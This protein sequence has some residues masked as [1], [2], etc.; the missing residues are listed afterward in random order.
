[1]NN[2]TSSNLNNDEIDISI[3]FNSL[4]RNKLI[5]IVF[6]LISTLSTYIYCLKA[7]PIFSGNFNIVVKDDENNL[8]GKNSAV[9]PGVLQFEKYDEQSET[10]L[11]ILRS[12]YVLRP[13]YKYVTSYYKEKGDIR[14]NDNYEDWLKSELQVEF[15]EQSKVLKIKYKNYEKDHIINVLNLISKKYQD[16]SKKS[17]NRNITKSIDYLL[18]QKDI[19][20]KKAKESQS[21]LNLFAIENGLSDID[22]FVDIKD[23]GFNNS[24][25]LSSI[26][27]NFAQQSFN[28]NLDLNN[29]INTS[30]TGIRFQRQ[31]KLLEIYESRYLDLSS[32]LKPNSKT[33]TTLEER[34]K[35]LKKS[36]RRPN[37][38]LLK[39]RELLRQSKL[40]NSLLVT[41][42]QDLAMYKLEKIKN[43]DP[44]LMI[45]VPTI[46]NKVVYPRKI[47]F[48]GISLIFSSIF[49]SLVIFVK[50][51]IT[52]IIY[53]SNELN[54]AINCKNIDKLLANNYQLSLK[55]L[56]NIIHKISKEKSGSKVLFL[57]YNTSIL[58]SVFNQYLKN[59][60]N[61]SVLNNIEDEAIMENYDSIFLIIELGKIKRKEILLLNEYIKLYDESLIGFISIEDNKN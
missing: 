24:L 13:I 40:D 10:Q 23:V 43:P 42:E 35:N 2:Q 29:D 54:A 34:I 37:E 56:K 51:R 8:E 32:K 41:I 7:R 17:R 46:D 39:Y 44:W 28:K 4:L 36:L 26:K 20:S 49:I 21:K 31:F 12:P 9:L 33:L 16:Y 47:R 61:L 14:M 57:Q 38:I 22:G 18:R 11:Y 60:S 45:S 15:I 59:N 58:D 25:D 1:M 50:E 5:I 52:G 48:T 3:F 27:A 6:T 55:K 53:E 19:M 30:N